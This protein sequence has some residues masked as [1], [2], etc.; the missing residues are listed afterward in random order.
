MFSP[1]IPIIAVL[2][3]LSFLGIMFFSKEDKNKAYIKFILIAY[4]L[5]AT[6]ILPGGFGINSEANYY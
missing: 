4:P 3:F 5:M 2:I 6:Y 1:Y